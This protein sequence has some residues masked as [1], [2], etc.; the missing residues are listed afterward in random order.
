M[1]AGSQ[2]RTRRDADA[3]VPR[4]TPGAPQPLDGPLARV[5]L[6]KEHAREQQRRQ[7]EQNAPARGPSELAGYASADQRGQWSGD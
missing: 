5:A 2:S 6:E 3:R 7:H 4:P 1:Y